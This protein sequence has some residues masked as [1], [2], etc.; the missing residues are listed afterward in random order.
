[1]SR[2]VST[3]AIVVAAAMYMTPAAPTKNAASTAACTDGMTDKSSM[4][5]PRASA[6]TITCR[7]STSR[8]CATTSVPATAPELMMA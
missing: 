4:V 2:R 3:C 8:L 5:Q 6:P 7:S 1:M